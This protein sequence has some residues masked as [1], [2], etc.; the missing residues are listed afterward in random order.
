MAKAVKKK[1]NPIIIGKPPSQM[2]GKQWYNRG[3]KNVLDPE[4]LLRLLPKS[5][6]VSYLKVSGA[7]FGG[8]LK[9]EQYWKVLD[10]SYMIFVDLGRCRIGI[11][12]GMPMNRYI[13][14]STKR[15]FESALKKIKKLFFI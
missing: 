9:E 6:A 2:K 8:A 4:E 7:S 10:N 13:C 3:G 5:K 15:D 11:V 14:A 1:E 12:R